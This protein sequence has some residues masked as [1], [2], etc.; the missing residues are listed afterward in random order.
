MIIQNAISSNHQLSISRSCQALDIS[1]SG[2][3]KWRKELQ[4]IPSENNENM[5]LRDEI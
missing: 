3:C 1:R 2:Y 4:A 5:A